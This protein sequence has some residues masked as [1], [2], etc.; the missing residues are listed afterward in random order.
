MT[1][2]FPVKIN[3]VPLKELMTVVHSV[4]K[5]DTLLQGMNGYS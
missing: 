2:S 3:T 4:T 5:T 1:A